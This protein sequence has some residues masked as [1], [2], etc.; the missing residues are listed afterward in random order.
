MLEACLDSVYGQTKRNS[1]EVIYV[2]NAS[3]DG[4]AEMVRQKFPLATV[5]SNTVNRGFVEANNQAI[6]VSRGRYVL[7]LNSDT[8]VLDDAIGKTAAFADM[9]PE[10]A[11]FGCRVLNSDLSLQRSCF[12]FPSVPNFIL[13]TSYLYKLFPRSAFFGREH[14]TWWNFD[15]SRE[16]ETV[17]GCFSLVRREA[18]DETGAMDPVFFFYGDDPDWCFRFRKAGWKA[19]F[20]PTARIIHH[21]GKSSGKSRAKF[22]L[23]LFGSELLFMKLHRGFPSFVAARLLVSLF[24]FVR[25]PL[26]VAKGIG[27]PVT[28]KSDFESARTYLKGGVLS[29]VDWK[30]MLMNRSEVAR[31]FSRR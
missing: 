16:V 10:G 23:Q 28:R 30:S 31:R 22:K 1:F 15:D 13:F 2:D 5:I 27:F 7:L 24:F 18:I 4:S 26:W 21:G 20:T 3:E 9:H 29:L 19:L 11:V 6:A 12:M 17:S 25:A 8:I 14:M